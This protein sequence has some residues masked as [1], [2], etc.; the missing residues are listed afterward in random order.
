MPWAIIG[1][2]GNSRC[3]LKFVPDFLSFKVYFIGKIAGI[4]LLTLFRKHQTCSSITGRKIYKYGDALC[5]KAKHLMNA[6]KHK[7]ESDGPKGPTTKTGML[8]PVAR[9]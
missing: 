3:M 9:N 8:L 5:Q 4:M 6:G 7:D 1:G 2:F